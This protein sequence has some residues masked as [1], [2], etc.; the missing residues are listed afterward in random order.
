M[1]AATRRS[2]EIE[3]EPEYG[4]F[5]SSGFVG[6]AEG[7]TL[8]FRRVFPLLP[9]IRTFSESENLYKGFSVNRQLDT[10]TKPGHGPVF[11]PKSI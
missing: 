2:S 3:S 7:K 1:G 10:T 5:R 8:G 6:G 11:E 4:A 9:E